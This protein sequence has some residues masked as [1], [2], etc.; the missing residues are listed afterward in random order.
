MVVYSPSMGD[1][2]ET[3]FRRWRKKLDLT[4]E[5][6][7]ELLQLSRSQ[8]ANLDRGVSRTNGVPNLPSYSIR[9]LMR[10]LAQ[11]KVPKPWPE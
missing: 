6:A 2:D 7:A 11:G 1:A 8:V 4:L 5:E 9:V 3:S 10:L